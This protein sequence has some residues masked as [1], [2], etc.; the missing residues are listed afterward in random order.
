[1]IRAVSVLIC[2]HLV[3]GGNPLNC[4]AM[5]KEEKRKKLAT[6]QIRIKKIVQ[7]N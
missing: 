3:E 4:C 7:E 5:E 1:M 2:F 6:K